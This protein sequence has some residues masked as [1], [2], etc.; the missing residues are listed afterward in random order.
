[1]MDILN[2]MGSVSLILRFWR[3]RNFIFS[4]AEGYENDFTLALERIGVFFPW[5][6]NFD[7]SVFTLK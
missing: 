3:N 4:Y 2:N 6:L 7:I 5:I 1:M